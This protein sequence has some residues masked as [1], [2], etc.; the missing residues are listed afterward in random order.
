MAKRQQAV[1]LYFEERGKGLPVVLLHG[2]PFSHHIWRAQIDA[3]TDSFRIIA[4]D[5]RGHG[6]SPA[7]LGTYDMDLMAS[8]VCALLD[9]LG[10]ERAA[11]AGHSLG[12]YVLMAALRRHPRYVRG[13]ALV[14][15]HPLPDSPDKRLQRMQS[16]EVVLSQGPADLALSMM[17]VLFAPKFDRQSPAAQAI[18]EMMTATPALGVAGALRGMA[19]RPDSV[20]TL[21]QIVVPAVVIAGVEDQIVKL[22]VAEEMA[23]SMPGAELVT[24]AGAGHM[25]MIEQPEAT[26]AVLREFLRTLPR[27]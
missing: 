23:R 15:T 7:P 2:F 4:P 13:A 6:Q 27:R 22:E 11:W 5:L 26:T 24:I 25:P 16:A 14:A 12:G 9:D 10:I 18:Y 3:L 8:D 19:G 1:G 21:R 20:E 17:A